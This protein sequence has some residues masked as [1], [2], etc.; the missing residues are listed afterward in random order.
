MLDAVLFDL[1]G[2]LTDPA[3]GITTSFR[4]ALEEVGYPVAADTDLTWMIGPPLRHN[5]ASIGL[6]EHLHDAAAVAYRTR[7]TDVGLFE[8][9]LVDGIEDVLRGLVDDGV[10]LA[11]A[12]MKPVDQAHTTLRHF[13][14]DGYFGVVAG[15]IADGLPVPKA[16]VVKDALHQLEVTDPTRVAM[17]G[18]RH[19]D[20]DGG[21]ENR[22][23]T[24]GVTWGYA[25]EGEL[26][27]TPPDHVV[28]TPDDLLRVLR[29]LP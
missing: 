9:A 6:P 26:E 4:H 10:A 13:G 12:T 16:A 22:C 25:Q 23:R 24:V 5:F 1:D 20:V 7:H 15:T 17:V 3:V 19:H 29:E 2:T 14:L 27:R 21:R 18:D 11:L 8:A 28:T